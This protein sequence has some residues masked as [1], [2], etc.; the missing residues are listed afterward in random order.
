ML[1]TDYIEK[2]TNIKTKIINIMILSPTSSNCHHHKVTNIPQSPTSPNKRAVSMLSKGLKS[3]KIP[4]RASA[5]VKNKPIINDTIPNCILLFSEI[6]KRNVL[7]TM[8]P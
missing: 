5:G 3:I 8:M 4:E 6:K 7:I 2:F 1:T